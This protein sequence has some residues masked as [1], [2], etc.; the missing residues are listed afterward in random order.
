MV[1][2]LSRLAKYASID[3]AQ[4]QRQFD[5]SAES[6]SPR[7]QAVLSAILEVAEATANTRVPGAA[8]VPTLLRLVEEIAG[9][10]TARA[11]E[12]AT[13]IRAG[14]RRV[15][16]AKTLHSLRELRLYRDADGVE[17]VWPH[18]GMLILN[19][20]LG[21]SFGCAYCF[22]ADEQQSNVDW[23]LNGRPTQVVSEETVVEQ[24]ARHPL[25]VPGVTQLGLHTATT[26]PFL[27]QV[28]ESTFRLLD[29][30]DERGWHNDVMVIT[31][32]YLT[33]EDAARLASYTSV[34]LLMFLTY[35]AAP[36][37]METMGGARG[38]RERRFESIDHLARYPHIAAAHYYR[39][40]VPGW[41][42]SDDQITDAL[43]F[44]ERLG[45]TVIGGLKEIPDLVTITRRRGLSLPTV[46]SGPAGEKYFPPS[47]VDRILGIH[48]DLGL[49]STVVGDQSCGLTVMM[50]GRAGSAVSNVEA[51]K[52]YD[53]L[54][55]R[56]PKCMALCPPDQLAA[57]ARPPA[58]ALATV[59]RLL[60][61]IGFDGAAEVT[62]TCVRLRSA[63]SP[64]TAELDSL[65]AHLRYAVTW[66][67]A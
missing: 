64:S 59:H 6:L 28:K 67:P 52:M 19:P 18:A 9:Q 63:V 5:T 14:L 41:N 12:D 29:L 17:P 46:A 13:T 4:L 44:G 2:N 38:F 42:D 58:P 30:L 47:L 45:L 15:V 54:S 55:P 33:A 36:A 26:E 53:A 62:E 43:T 21:C 24:L 56:R 48:R 11:G 61:H 66:Q 23:F 7:G 34:R 40:I 10:S 49:T 20:F 8:V 39:P 57:C 35:N 65:S 25:F 3:A 37:E 50:S 1:P 31:K 16:S 32:H 27:P 60:A 22:R 51:L